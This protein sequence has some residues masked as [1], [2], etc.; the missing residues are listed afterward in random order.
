M[1]NVTA[2]TSASGAAAYLTEDNYYLDKGEAL[3]QFY[4]RGAE[5]LGLTNQ[6]VNNENI[7]DL[8]K[9]AL[10]DGTQVGAIDKHRPGWDATFQL[11]SQYLFKH[12]LL[13]INVS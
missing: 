5:K 6:T 4:G 9:G 12:W 2:L 11:Q 8:L 10:P 3:A 1:M 7:T 13:E